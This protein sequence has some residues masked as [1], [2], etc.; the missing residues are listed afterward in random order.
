[1]GATLHHPPRNNGEDFTGASV[2]DPFGGILGI[3]QNPHCLESLA[4]RTAS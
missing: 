3:M 2:I 4:T 1:M